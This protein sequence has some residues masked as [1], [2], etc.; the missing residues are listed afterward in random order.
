MEHE[1]EWGLNGRSNAFP[2][3]VIGLRTIDRLR[4][5]NLWSE[6][7]PDPVSN[8][9]FVFKKKN[10]YSTIAEVQ[11]LFSEKECT[12][13]C[14][15]LN[16]FISTAE[17][18]KAVQKKH[19]DEAKN[20][21]LFQHLLFEPDKIQMEDLS[22]SYDASVR[23]GRRMILLEAHLT[24]IIW[25]RLNLLNLDALFEQEHISKCPRGFSVHP[26]NNWRFS[27]VN[28]CIRVN[29][30][31]ESNFF[32]YHKDSQYCPS[33]N[34][35]SL[36]SGII[37]LNDGFEGGET[38]VYFP[39]KCDCGKFL[40]ENHVAPIVSSATMQETLDSM[41]NIAEKSLKTTPKAGNCLLFSPHLLHKGEPLA[42]GSKWIIRFDVLVSR[43]TCAIAQKQAS[44]F[45]E[46]CVE[47]RNKLSPDPERAENGCSSCQGFIVHPFERRYYE[48]ALTHFRIAQTLELEKNEENKKTVS[49]SYDRCLSLRYS[50]PQALDYILRF[51]SGENAVAEGQEITKEETG[52]AEE[53]FVRI[54]AN[55]WD[56]IFTLAGSKAAKNFALA[57]PMQVGLR[58]AE[59]ERKRK[60]YY[61]DY[62]FWEKTD[63]FIPILRYQFGYL[64]C[65]EFPDAD[66][67][68][69]NQ[70]DCLR[71][72]AFYAF[73]LIG[74][75]KGCPPLQESKDYY[76]REHDNSYYTVRYDPTDNT[77]CA[78]PIYELLTDVFYNRQSFGCIYSVC[79]D[80]SQK[81]AKDFVNNVDRS[82]IRL[83]HKREFIGLDY[84]QILQVNE[85][86]KQIQD[87]LYGIKAT[88]T[89]EDGTCVTSMKSARYLTK[90]IHKSSTYFSFARIGISGVDHKLA[91]PARVGF[92]EFGRDEVGCCMIAND[93]WRVYDLHLCS[94][95]DDL[96]WNSSYRK[97]NHLVFNFEEQKLVVSEWQV[98]YEPNPDNW[99]A[100]VSYHTTEEAEMY[101]GNPDNGAF[102]KVNVSQLL[103]TPDLP[104]NHAACSCYGTVNKEHSEMFEQ[105]HYPRLKDVYLFVY[106]TTANTVLVYATYEAIA[107]L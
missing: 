31:E 56:Q 87:Y 85:K 26:E 78:I 50:F 24:K 74:Q 62:P 22:Q 44:K 93:E 45:D 15:T 91:I 71:V 107:C 21:T 25:E 97:I 75:C 104:F 64:S 37:Y 3:R 70:N 40:D 90:R 52:I 76:N 39:E 72:A 69:N 29:I 1:E 2:A 99:L 48:E 27:G 86:K 54:P 8:L 11:Q 81:P 10:C 88:K 34:E 53:Y 68:R 103:S 67:F 84:Q 28:P 47:C 33:S 32:N 18:R 49:A 6:I 9:K 13:L 96:A 63:K 5:L 92:A 65:F 79:H 51:Q 80:S 42:K 83:Q 106:F 12:Q 30:Y 98:E 20:K 89:N 66:F 95:T 59:W 77:I 105:V 58:R 61:E 23:S 55:V 17:A 43:S 57:F 36:L 102:Y 60:E 19:E 35:R 100:R 14:K 73:S 7:N 38:L 4:K 41:P 94:E 101:G 82:W 16:N 46:V